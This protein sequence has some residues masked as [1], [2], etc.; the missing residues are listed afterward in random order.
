MNS[1]GSQDAF[2]D[3]DGEP[4]GLYIRSCTGNK[5]KNSEGKEVAETTANGECNASAQRYNVTFDNQAVED[6]IGE[7]VPSHAILIVLKA[8]CQGE[9][10]I[11]SS[12]ARKVAV[13][14]KKEGGG[15]FCVNN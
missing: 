10:A 8:T 15:T 14:Y 11:P 6:G 4:Y 2:S 9:A 1:G 5:T 7:G 13:L 3:P 12:G